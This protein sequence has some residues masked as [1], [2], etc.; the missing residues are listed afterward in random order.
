MPPVQ[1]KPTEP[2]GFLKVGDLVNIVSRGR[3]LQSYEILGFDE[4]YLKVRGDITVAPQTEVVLLPHAQIEALGL[5]N[6]R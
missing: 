2:E 3:T 1:K 6:E 4:N 5:I